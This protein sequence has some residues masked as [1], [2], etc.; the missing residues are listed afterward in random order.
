MFCERVARRRGPGG[1][2]SNE[3]L[4]EGAAIARD[5]RRADRP[6]RVVERHRGGAFLVLNTV[7]SDD[8]GPGA[9]VT[10]PDVA[11][12]AVDSPDVTNNSLTGADVNEASLDAT[13]LRT[14]IAQG[15][16]QPAVAGTG[17]MVTAGAV[18]IDKYEASVWSSPTGGTQ[19]ASTTDDY[20][21]DD[22]GQ[23][24]NRTSTP[25][26]SPASRPRASS[27]GSRPSR[28]SPTPAS[29]CRPTPS[30]SRR[31]PARPDSTACAGHRVGGEHRRSAGVRLA[32]R[33][34][35]HG[36]KPVRVG[37]R[38]GRAG[39]RLRRRGRDLR[40]FHVLR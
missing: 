15:G 17:T 29:A 38:L 39:G 40:A 28:R 8:L 33:R 31:S 18:C 30:G 36:R 27:P 37:R 12:N 1:V 9:Q 13:P 5:G 21:C 10:A 20:P 3:G 35:R 22:N 6:V 7:Q 2:V 32:L 16:C 11:T 25:A 23:D 26:A 24:C 34:L 14:R 19:S 4:D